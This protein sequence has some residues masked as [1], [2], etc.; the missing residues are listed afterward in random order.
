[1]LFYPNAALKNLFWGKLQHPKE[2]LG[3][4]VCF[5]IQQI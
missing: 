5:R 3:E 1:M 2:L 4:K